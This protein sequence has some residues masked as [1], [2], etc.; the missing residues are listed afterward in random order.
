MIAL[1]NF[2]QSLIAGVLIGSLY[3][4]MCVGLG[5]IFG[6]MRVINF[7]QGEFFMLGMYG[8]FYLFGWMGLSGI[9]GP[10]LAAVLSAGFSFAMGWG[11][12]R[13]L[14]SNST[15]RAVAGTEG[16]G[17]YQQ[18]ILTL[19]VSLVLANG[20]LLVFGNLPLS[21][22]T[23]YASKAWELGP[24]ADD[25]MLMFFF[26]QARV[27]ALVAAVAVTMATYLFISRSRLGK[28]L[29]AAADNPDAATYMGI[30]VERAHRISFSLGVAITAIAGGLVASYYPFQP[31]IGLEFVVIMYAG[32]VLGGLG[33]IMGP[34]W[35]G[36][37]IGLVQQLSALFLPMQ[38]QNGTIFVLFLLVILFRPQGL[39]GKNVERV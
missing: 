29:R 19:G 28:T 3:G 1:E 9:M 13:F 21:I 26:N 6:L 24:L 14:L 17:H 35:G 16:D 18:L 8:A 36:L 7:A 33:S 23:P 20:A 22:R 4:L 2:L 34:F 11:V 30:D 15:G 25:G 38:L 27:M 31:Y 10:L 37:I 5:L 39:F 12:H 32:V